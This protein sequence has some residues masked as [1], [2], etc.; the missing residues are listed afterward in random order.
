MSIA[1]LYNIFNVAGTMLLTSLCQGTYLDNYCTYVEKYDYGY[2][3][4]YS[5]SDLK[6]VK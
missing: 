2:W 1:I 6:L 4:I 3:Y 5:I